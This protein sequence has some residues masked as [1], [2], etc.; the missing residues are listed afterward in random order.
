MVGK[1]SDQSLTNV[2]FRFPFKITR[3]SRGYCP[4][5]SLLNESSYINS[6]P[7]LPFGLPAFTFLANLSNIAS[8]ALLI[9]AS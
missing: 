2:V 8:T 1:W 6:L 7:L 3:T 5:I 4:I 9:P